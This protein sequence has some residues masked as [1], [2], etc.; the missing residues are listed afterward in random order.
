LV[1]IAG[2]VASDGE[3][4]IIGP[5]DTAVQARYAFD[6][7]AEVMEMHGGSITDVVEVTSF[8]KDARAW[9]I[10]LDVARDYFPAGAEPAWT[11]VGTTGLWNPGYLH[12]IYALGVLDPTGQP[13]D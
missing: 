7:I 8:H 2:E 3:G 13:L 12:E 6:R 9:E 1:G 5:G 10:V 11:P 4:R